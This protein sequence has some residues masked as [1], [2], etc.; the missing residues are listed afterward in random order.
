MSNKKVRANGQGTVFKLS[1]GKWRVEKTIYTNGVKVKRITKS[2]FKL[3]RD[4][5][6]YLNKLNA[7]AIRLTAS[8]T[9][10]EIYD[11]WSV[12]HYAKIANDTSNGYKAAYKRCENIWYRQ[13]SSLKASDLQEI[14]DACPLSRRTKADIKLMLSMLYKFALQNDYCD[15]DYAQFIKLPPKGKPKHDAFT[16][17]ERDV[18]WK[19]YNSGNKFTG[20]ILF[21]I[22]CGLR[23]GEYA[24]T[25][26]AKMYL[27]KRYFISGIKTPAGID[28]TIPI[29]DCIYNITDE[30]YNKTDKKYLLTVPEK[31]WYTLYHATLQRLGIR[32]LDTHCC[33]HTAAT[34]LAEADVQPAIILAILGH[35]NYSMTLNYTHISLD[36]ML[37]AVN[38]QY[39]PSSN[40]K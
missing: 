16:K 25:E 26:R 12:P 31:T 22:Y 24:K 33:R 29:A 15:K 10:K 9:F 1:S 5:L 11:L 14:V 36:E 19:D 4:A 40:A 39:I 20:E 18:L 38:K 21:L 35:E 8:A 37:S 13:F 30:L 6:D 3:K 27:D 17:A 7:G 34:A 2:G 23:F 32:D 28:R